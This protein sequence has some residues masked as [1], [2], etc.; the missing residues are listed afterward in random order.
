MPPRLRGHAHDDHVHVAQERDRR[1]AAHRHRRR[2]RINT[3]TWRWRSMPLAPDSPPAVRRQTAA[4]TWSSWRGR[5]PSASW[6]RSASKGPAPT[7]RVASFVRRA[8]AWSRSA[9]AT[10]ESDATTARA[11]R[12]IRCCRG[13]R[14]PS[15]RPP[16]E[17]VRQIKIARDTAVK[18][19]SAAIITLKSLIVNASDALRESLDPLTDRNSSTVARRSPG[20]ILDPTASA[21]HS[22]RDRSQAL[23]H[24]GSGHPDTRRRPRRDHAHSRTDTP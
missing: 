19:R 6:R 24:P 15:R 13:S 23:A 11:I 12:S 5:A 22:L 2:T 18:A 8:S 4:A 3:F 7:V 17:M 1:A 14:Q 10:G 16:T 20:D 9:I 21:K